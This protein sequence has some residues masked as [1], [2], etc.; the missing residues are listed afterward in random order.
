[1][2]TA[3]KGRIVTWRYDRSARRTAGVASCCPSADPQTTGFAAQHGL[4]SKDER[5]SVPKIALALSKGCGNPT[6]YAKLRPGETVVV[7]FAPHMVQR[8]RQAIAEAGLTAVA[9]LQLGELE[10]SGF[11]DDFADIVISNCV[12]NL[13]ASKAAAYR[14]AFRNLKPGGR[15]AISDIVYAESPDPAVKARFEAT[16]AGC[17]GGAIDGDT[18]FQTVKDAGFGEIQVVAMHPLAPKELEEMATCPGPEFTAAPAP[19]DLLAVQGKVVSI[20][21]T[22]VGQ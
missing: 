18:Y 9:D 21:F 16:W 2:K 8:A 3:E 4:Y 15:L 19:E 22:A 10:R 11:P 7:D 6:S 12:I 13:L 17:V 1:M 14:E 20:K 5:S